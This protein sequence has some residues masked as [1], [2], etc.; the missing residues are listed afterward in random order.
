MSLSRITNGPVAGRLDSQEA[1]QELFQ[2]L[3]FVHEAE[4]VVGAL[5]AQVRRRG[6][7]AA[8]DDDVGA[9]DVQMSRPS[10][11]HE[12]ACGYRACAS[13]RERGLKAAARRSGRGADLFGNTNRQPVVRWRGFVSAGEELAE[14]PQD[15]EHDCGG[16]RQPELPGPEGN[17]V[18]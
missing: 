10:D 13:R 11:N 5:V 4:R 6:E 2:V 1:V 16:D 8:V 15:Q 14:F 9:G 18:E 3:L 7:P 12:F 17:G